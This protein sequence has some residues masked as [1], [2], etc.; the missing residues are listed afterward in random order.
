MER[1]PQMASHWEQQR[2]LREAEAGWG[3]NC[4]TGEEGLQRAG[5]LFFGEVSADCGSVSAGSARL[6]RNDL[7]LLTLC[8]AQTG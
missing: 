7:G 1:A 2:A 4:G 8:E 3:R 5:F 6:C